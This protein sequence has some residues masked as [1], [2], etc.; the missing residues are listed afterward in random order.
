MHAGGVE[1]RA[2]QAVERREDPDVGRVATERAAAD[3]RE[4]LDV[5]GADVA[6]AGLERHDVAQLRGGDLRRHDRDERSIAVDR[7]RDHAV[8]ERDRGG[9]QR[10]RHA[11]VERVQARPDGGADHQPEGDLRRPQAEQSEEPAADDPDQDRVTPEDEPDQPAEDRHHQDAA[12]GPLPQ[13]LG[14]RGRPVARRQ[15][16][17]GRVHRGA[18]HGAERRPDARD[19]RAEGR[20][21]GRPRRDT[22]H[23][24]VAEPARATAPASVAS[25]HGCGLSRRCT[26][27]PS[28][29][30]R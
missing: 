29:V 30:I 10:G 1:R 28:V 5:V 9:D 7:R 23:R 4:L 18:D 24:R 20:A 19:P 16:L 17:E 2:L 11:R 26:P 6:R 15:D 12:E 3:V 27:A 14:L 8:G 13:R 22:P 25:G 21:A